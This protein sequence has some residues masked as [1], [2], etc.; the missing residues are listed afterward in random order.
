VF[1][2]V[3]PRAAVYRP[4]RRVTTLARSTAGP[5]FGTVALVVSGAAVLGAAFDRRGS[6]HRAGGG[7]GGG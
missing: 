3:D 7:W 4:A 6:W 5:S 2:V 1:A